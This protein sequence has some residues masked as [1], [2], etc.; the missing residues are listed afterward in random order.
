MEVTFLSGHALIYKAVLSLSYANIRSKPKLSNP[1]TMDQ[2]PFTFVDSSTQSLTCSPRFPLRIF[3]KFQAK[4]GGVGQTLLDK[5]DSYL[6]SLTGQPRT[7]VQ[8][9][10]LA[11]DLRPWWSSDIPASKFKESPLE[12]T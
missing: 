8:G 1:I 10:G 5:R 9:P 12:E 11:V 4:S 2:V 3:E 6:E 7:K